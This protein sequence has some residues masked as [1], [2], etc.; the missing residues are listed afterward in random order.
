MTSRLLKSVVAGEQPADDGFGVGRRDM[1]DAGIAPGVDDAGPAL[2][3][4]DREG[5]GAADVLARDQRAHF[6]DAT[7]GDHAAARDH[8]DAVGERFGLL[9]VVRRQ[10]DRAAVVEQAADRAPHGLARRDVE[11]HGRLVEEQQPRPPADGGRELHLALLAGRELAVALVG[12]RL[13][14]GERERLLDRERVAVVARR[15][16]DELA[17]P[18]HGGQSDLLHHDADAEPAL[19]FE[20]RAAHERD[21]AVVGL[22]QAEPQADG[23][24]LAGAVR[25]EQSEQLAGPHREGQAVERYGLAVTFHDVRELRDGRGR[26]AARCSAAASAERGAAGVEPPRSWA[27]RYRS[28]RI[29]FAVECTRAA[30]I[31]A[32]IQKLADERRP[33][34]IVVAH[35]QHRERDREDQRELDVQCSGTFIN[36]ACRPNTIGR[37][38][39]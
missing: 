34:E 13:G 21:F 14:A 17:R 11:P 1:H 7:L 27:S 19:H 35:E 10:H 33:H 16:R 30:R 32:A 25:T 23:R 12:E 4:V 2:D 26:D 36:S 22:E 20:R 28:A 6:L 8:D 24:R 15:E 3:L 18:Q 31:L 38:P 5:G 39:R 29:R 37:W 9:E